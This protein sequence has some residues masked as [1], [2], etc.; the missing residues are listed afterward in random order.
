MEMALIYLVQVTKRIGQ[1]IKKKNYLTYKIP[2]KHLFCT[3]LTSIARDN[4]IPTAAY[5]SFQILRHDKLSGN[6]KVPENSCSVYW[7]CSGSSLEKI[8]T[9]IA[10]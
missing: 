10:D 1:E 5:G 8:P 3:L 7:S 4:E 2:E 6:I 9:T